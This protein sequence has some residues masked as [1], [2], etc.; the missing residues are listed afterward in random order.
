MLHHT[1]LSFI[2][3]GGGIAV[4]VYAEQ[5]KYYSLVAI[6]HKTAFLQGTSIGVRTTPS[7]VC[8][9]ALITLPHRYGMLGVS[10]AILLLQFA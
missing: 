1:Q 4:G 10:F 8:S 9:G 6:T 3:L 7:Q 5:K 2:Q